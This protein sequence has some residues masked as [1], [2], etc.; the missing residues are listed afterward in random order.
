MCMKV[1][2]NTVENLKSIDQK[3]AQSIV[4]NN[5]ICCQ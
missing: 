5:E 2:E 3:S 4:V 1:K